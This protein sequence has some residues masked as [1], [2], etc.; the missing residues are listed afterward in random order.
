MLGLLCHRFRRFKQIFFSQI[1]Q[2]DLIN[3]RPLICGIGGIKIRCRNRKVAARFA[4]EA[5]R[6]LSFITRI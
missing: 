5:Q 2:V 4:K 1:A 3:L 6:A